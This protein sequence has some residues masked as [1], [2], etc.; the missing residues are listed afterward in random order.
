VRYRIDS[1]ASRLSIRTLASGALS[2]FGHDPTFVARDVGGDMT[3]EADALTSA[4]LRL[5]IKADSLALTG[6]VN[7]SD[8]QEIER[9]TLQEVLETATYP[10]ITYVC[11]EGQ[12]VAQGLMQLTLKGELSLHGVTRPQPVAT[13]LFM[14]GDTVR[15]QGEASV[16]QSD[17]GIRLVTAV[18]GMLRVK[19]E[20]KLTF[21]IVAR[22]VAEQEPATA[23][24]RTS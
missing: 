17:Y 2:V 3:L 13:R 9:R 10:E 1:P 11:R 23:G 22:L 16:R 19:D 7:D 4:S 12:V 8:R 18:G 15:A 6:E 5:V 20:V 24:A 21:D 14:A